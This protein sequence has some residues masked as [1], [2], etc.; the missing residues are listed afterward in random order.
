MAEE[1]GGVYTGA[2]QGFME[3][4]RAFPHTPGGMVF[5]DS[6][7]SLRNAMNVAFIGFKVRLDDVIIRLSS[8][9]TFLI[10]YAMSTAYYQATVSQK[11]INYAK[12]SWLLQ[13]PAYSSLSCDLGPSANLNRFYLKNIRIH[14]TTFN[15]TEQ[16]FCDII[17]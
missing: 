15:F 14:C 7:G 5:I 12:T 8:H 4:T 6:W 16:L 1:F 9:I 17:S 10:I 2:V 3:D 11:T 13:T